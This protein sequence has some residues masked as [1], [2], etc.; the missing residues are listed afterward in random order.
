MDHWFD[1]LTKD[2]AAY[3]PSRRTA[4]ASFA[5]ALA[6]GATRPTPRATTPPKTAN[7]GP[8]TVYSQDGHYE[9][10]LVSRASAGGHN[11]ELRRTRTIDPKT[12]TTHDTTILV[13]GKQQLELTSTFMKSAETHKFTFG[14]GFVPGGAMLTSTDGGKTFRGSIAGKTIAPYT[15]GSG[16]IQF[17]NGA[18]PKRAQTPGVS[19]AVKAVAKQADA[20]LDKCSA[21]ARDVPAIRPLPPKIVAECGG[22]PGNTEFQVSGNHSAPNMT[23]GEYE[24]LVGL[25]NHNGVRQGQSTTNTWFSKLCEACNNKCGGN[26]FDEIV[27]VVGC[28]VEA[29]ETYCADGCLRCGKAVNYSSKQFNCQQGCQSGPACDPVPCGYNYGGGQSSCLHDEICVYRGNYNETFGSTGFVPPICCPKTHPK[30]CGRAG[31]IYDNA[32]GSPWIGGYCCGN[33]APCIFDTRFGSQ[34]DSF[35]DNGYYCCPKAQICGSFKNGVYVGVCCFP[36]QHCCDGMCCRAN[37]TCAKLAG[38]DGTY[39]GAGSA[40]GCCPKEHIRDGKCCPNEHR[41]GNNEYCCPDG[42]ANGKCAEICLSGQRTRNGTCC[43]GNI[44]CGDACCEN[45]CADPKTS[46]CKPKSTKCASGHYE[47]D[48]YPKGYLA[49]ET[50]CCPKGQVCYEKCC[51]PRTAACANLKGVWGCWPQAQCAPTPPPPK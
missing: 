47:C 19:D 43:G 1:S 42:C 37:Q 51:P 31:G 32:L 21:G 45:G 4:L 46:K 25:A 33:E 7:F 22:T 17:T 30:P 27:N 14:D 28:L 38:Y 2:L 48:F 34:A 12:G 13:D 35:N 11:A 8:C 5:T 49:K 18:P 16:E 50:I 23:C 9:H 24:L 29:Y 3:K 41:C 36:Q 20:E 39:T 15:I 40:T 26:L 44:A 6:M 10:H